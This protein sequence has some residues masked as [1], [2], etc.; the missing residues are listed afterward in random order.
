MSDRAPAPALTRYIVSESDT[1]LCDLRAAGG[2]LLRCGGGNG[3]G[4][5]CLAL[6]KSLKTPCVR[7]GSV[8][9]RRPCTEKPGVV[10]ALY[11]W[12]SSKICGSTAACR[13]RVPQP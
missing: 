5:G 2:P 12:E 3:P 9:R 11:V 10:F 8:C 13:S 4:R 1:C 6:L 7:A